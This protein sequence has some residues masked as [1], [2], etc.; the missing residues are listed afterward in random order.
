MKRVLSA[1][2]TLSF[3]AAPA[4]LLG[5]DAAALK[6][7]REKQSYAIGVEM[8]NNMKRQGVDLDGNLVAQGIRDILSGGKSLLTEAEVK[9]GVMA[10]QKELMAKHQAVQKA[11]GDKAKAEGEAFLTANAKKDGVKTLPSG[12]QY[13]VVTEGTGATPKAT[14]T[15]TVNYRG[16]LVDGTEFDSSYSRNE[17]TTFPVKGVIPGWTEALQL[18]KV[19][20]KW[21]LYIPANLA[22]GERGAGGKIPANAALIFEVELLAIK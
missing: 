5:E 6:T 15:V 17:P 14:D 7:D 9:D 18:M 21:E 8:G 22:Y 10:F 16:K 2:V 4:L 20:S 1:V 3:L 19:G 11:A 13:K 12:L